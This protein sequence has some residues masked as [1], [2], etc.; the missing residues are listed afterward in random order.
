[1][2]TKD[3]FCILP[4]SS[5]VINPSGDF[6][7]CCFS[8]STDLENYRVNTHGMSVDDD[9]NV[10]N[11][12]THSIKEALNSKYHKEIRLAQSRNERHPMC[13][14]CWD[15]DD[16]NA[17]AGQQTN[18]LRYTR[19]FKQ[20]PNLENAITIHKVQD[21][22]TPDG[23]LDE[24]P[25]SL[26]LR[27]TNVCNMKCVMCSSIYSN[28]WYEDEMKLYNKNTI[29]IGQKIYKVEKL[30]GVFKTDMPVW[31]NS[32]NWWKEFELIKHRIRHLY[33][34]GGEPFIVKGHDTLLD[35]LIESGLA[36]QVI[37]E[38]DTNLSVINDKI[39]DRLKHF[40]KVI[41]SISCDDVNE[42]YELIR[43]P[44]KFSTILQNL[45]KLKDRNVGIR[46]LSSCVGIYSIY[47]PIRL[48]EYFTN[49]GYTTEKSTEKYDMYSF[50]ILRS[51]AHSNIALLPKEAKL[52]VID[53]YQQSSLPIKWK[54][55]LCGYLQNNM[56]T[57]TEEECIKSTK[58]HIEFL[59]KLD[60]LRGTNWKKTLPEVAELLKE[61]L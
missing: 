43:F 16:A 25:I 6:K 39:L 34:T 45:E 55:Y 38:Y 27:F 52:K 42:Q 36:S 60:E 17:T 54:N 50:R 33:L 48:Y 53:V 47:S 15:R 58:K 2:F 29:N 8:G 26:D 31:H 10:M 24:T 37:L 1:M 40:K 59:D 21:F 30:N 57:Y 20:L 14:V 23:S 3:T 5:I 4:W 35:K 61:Y 13:K 22:L 7:I 49:L 44:G 9:G 51:P 11:I 41:L 12:M 32:E 28:Q 18:S 56:D 19:S 46:H